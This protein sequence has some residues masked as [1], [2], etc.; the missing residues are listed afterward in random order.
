MH[1]YKRNPNEATARREIDR[2][3]TPDS[4]LTDD[5]PGPHEISELAYE[6]WV[7]RG[8]PMGSPDEDWFR[9]EQQLL[10]TGHS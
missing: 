4:P 7:E 2:V 5:A 6:L 1:A 9:A 10:H 3:E 8:Y